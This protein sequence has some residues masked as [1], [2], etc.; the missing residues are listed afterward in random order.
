LHGVYPHGA[1]VLA[2]LVGD[3]Q[4]CAARAAA[5]PLDEVGTAAPMVDWTSMR[6]ETQYTRLF[7]S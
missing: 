6:H 7:R 1:R 5:I 2:V 4:E 3:V